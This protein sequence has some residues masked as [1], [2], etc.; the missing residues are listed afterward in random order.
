MGGKDP[1]SICNLG[2]LFPSWKVSDAICKGK[3][4]GREGHWIGQSADWEGDLV[5]E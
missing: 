3:G 2:V 4:K 5:G 1:E